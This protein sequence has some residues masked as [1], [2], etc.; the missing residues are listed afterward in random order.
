MDNAG[1]VALS[2]QAGLLRELNTVANN[3]ANV[4]TSGYR[5]EGS[6]FAEHIKA[7]EGGD[8]SL[9]IATLDHRYV[10]FRAGEVSGSDNPLDVAIDGDGFF[11]VES[12]GG[13]RLTRAGSF[14]LS[15]IG[16]LVSADGRRVLNEGGGAL[17]V[18]PQSGSVSIAGDGTITADGQAIGRLGVVVA[19]PAYLVR[20]GDNTFRAERGYQAATNP[21]VRQNALEGSNV[22]A[23]TEISHLIEVQR[24]YEAGSRFLESE[25]ERIRRT[26]RELGD[27]RRS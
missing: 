17:V 26:V 13:P 21:R 2:R 9:S 25:D 12:A 6:I 10:D 20:E 7:L 14:S 3:I 22:S 1:Y 15:A 8:P 23:V 24:A 19:D 11:L 18:P 16:E 27:P 5:R 4:S